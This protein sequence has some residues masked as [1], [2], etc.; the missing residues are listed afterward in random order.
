MFVQVGFEGKR[1]VAPFT[2]EVFE[3]RMCLHVS[4]KIGPDQERLEIREKWSKK[5]S[6]PTCQQRIS[7]NERSR[8]V[9][10]RCE[11]SYVLVATRDD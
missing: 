5:T 7:H 9:Y 6:F 1:L 11:I 3:S 8:R 4:T 10:L 2:L